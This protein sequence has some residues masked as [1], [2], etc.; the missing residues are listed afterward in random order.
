MIYALTLEEVEA[1][2]DWATDQYDGSIDKSKV[3]VFFKDEEVIMVTDECIISKRPR[4]Y[5]RKE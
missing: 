3:T 4:D 1:I 5:F 2:A